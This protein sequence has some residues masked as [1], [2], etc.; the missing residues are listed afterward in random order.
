MPKSYD[1]SATIH[2]V[3]ETVWAVLTDAAGYS[4]WN[5]G[6]DHI[7]GTIAPGEKIKVHTTIN[8]GRA[9]PVRVSEFR[10]PERMVWS[11]GMP[12]GLFTGERT[13]TLTP[14]DE[15]ITEFSMREEFTGLLLPLV[16]RSMPDLTES[17][18]QFALGLKERVEGA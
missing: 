6:V 14:G 11:G 4:Q 17:F 5:S 13:F 18:Q 12:L 2:A 8:P 3:P 1:A 7:E 16:W 9:F 15:G 10:R